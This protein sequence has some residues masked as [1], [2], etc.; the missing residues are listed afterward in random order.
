MLSKPGAS[1]T[2]VPAKAALPGLGTE[3]SVKA[4]LKQKKVD[5]GT[6]M[7]DMDDYVFKVT[8]IDA[9]TVT[10]Q[11]EEEQ[12]VLV[13]ELFGKYTVITDEP[14]AHSLE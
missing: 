4:Q 6:E 11:G 5:I 14:Q 10:L 8:A 1:D 13:G 7:R 3:E 2:G 12:V 9:E